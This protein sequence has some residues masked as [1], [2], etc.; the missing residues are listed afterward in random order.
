RM[1][2]MHPALSLKARGVTPTPSRGHLRF[3]VAHPLP[4]PA[5]RICCQSINSAN[6]LGASSTMKA[7]KDLA[8]DVTKGSVTTDSA[9]TQT[10]FHIIRLW[11]KELAQAYEVLSDPEKRE[12]YDQY[13]EDALK[14][15]MGGG[16]GMHDPFD[17]FQSFFGV[18]E[19]LLEG[20]GETISD[21]DRC[22]QCKG[23]KVVSKKK[24][25]EV[26]VEK[27]MQN[28]QKIT[29]PSEADEAKE[30][31][32]FKRKGDDLFY[33]HTLTLVES[34]CGFQFVLTHLDNMQLLIKSNPSEVVKP[35]WSSARPWR[36]FSRP[37]QYH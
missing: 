37:S 33:E 2:E 26:V 6:V 34:L 17:T 23:D 36:L 22:P 14:V 31:P 11:F 30:H 27:G 19:A 32:K 9:V 10:K 4:R 20:S 13:G 24:V 8:L 7:L 15:G 12:I 3:H 16:G 1:Y 21:K 29:F 18:V 25:L 35:A 28:G 5:R